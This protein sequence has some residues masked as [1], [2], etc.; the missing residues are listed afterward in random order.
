VHDLSR[1]HSHARYPVTLTRH[2]TKHPPRSVRYTSHYPLT[3]Y[4]CPLLQTPI[5]PVSYTPSIVTRNDAWCLPP[6]LHSPLP[7]RTLCTVVHPLVYTLMNR[8]WMDNFVSHHHLPRD[9]FPICST[10]LLTYPSLLFHHPFSPRPPPLRLP[11]S[12]PVLSCFLFVCMPQ[13]SI[14]GSTVHSAIT[15]NK[16]SVELAA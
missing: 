3:R 2:I 8:S 5:Y 6:L 1:P 10:C 12:V 15:L 11:I 14:A 7:S 16:G 9:L 13:L 4:L